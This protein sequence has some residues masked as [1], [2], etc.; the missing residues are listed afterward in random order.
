LFSVE[1]IVRMSERE[2]YSIGI[3]RRGFLGQRIGG[4]MEKMHYGKV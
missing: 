4:I 3:V 2:S 1:V